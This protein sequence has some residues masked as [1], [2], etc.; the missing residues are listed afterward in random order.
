VAEYIGRLEK[1]GPEAIG[2]FY[3]AGHGA[4]N[5]KYGENYLIPIAASIVS[6]TQLP[7]QGVKVGEIVD[8]IAATSVKANFVVFDA[9]RNVPMSYSVRS[10]TRGLRP[11]AHRPGILI[12]FATDPG[13]TASDEGIYAEALT[14]EMQKP[15]VLA[16]EVFRAV[17][18]R[19]LKA[20]ENQQF[21]W[22]ENGLI[23]NMY[24]KP[25]STAFTPP[26]PALRSRQGAGFAQ[27][28][29]QICSRP[30]RRSGQG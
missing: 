28:R 13:K 18:S 26:E 1:A 10:A 17:R 30:G 12:A 3:Y 20:T 23:E 7:L 14:E 19:V 9:C 11:E 2:F 25:P 22:I 15:G 24:F 16:T 5:S 4:A 21:P 6:D 8:S 27:P 29:L